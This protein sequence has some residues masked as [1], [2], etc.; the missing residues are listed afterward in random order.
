MGSWIQRIGGGGFG[1]AKQ[2]GEGGSKGVSYS[3]S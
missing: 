2:I 1:G 3:I